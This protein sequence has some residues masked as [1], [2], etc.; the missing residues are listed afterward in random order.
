MGD[1]VDR[2]RSVPPAP[3]FNRVLVPGDPE[4]AS[5]KARASTI[6]IPDKTWDAVC[7]TAAKVGLSPAELLR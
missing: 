6:P 3:G 4:A 7:A 5:R 1:V 2:L